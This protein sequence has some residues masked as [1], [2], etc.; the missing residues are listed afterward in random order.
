[1]TGANRIDD[2]SDD[3]ERKEAELLAQDRAAARIS[4]AMDS[5]HSK[6][7]NSVPTR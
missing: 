5:G 4:T 1:M 2:T 3:Y 7:A 6:S